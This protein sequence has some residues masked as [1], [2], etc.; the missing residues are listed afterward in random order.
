MMLTKE[1]AS[2]GDNEIEH[3]NGEL[4]VDDAHWTESKM[5]FFS[6]FGSLLNEHVCS[7]RVWVFIIHPTS[8][9]FNFN[10]RFT[11]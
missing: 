8:S 7:E 5:F 1:N 3:I 11:L 10:A 2:Y 4:F 9:N 6:L